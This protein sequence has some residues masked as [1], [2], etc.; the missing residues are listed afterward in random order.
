MNKDISHITFTNKEAGISGTLT[1]ADGF[2]LSGRSSEC[3]LTS[4]QLAGLQKEIYDAICLEYD[5]L[6]D[7]ILTGKH[8]RREIIS[9]ATGKMEKVV[10]EYNKPA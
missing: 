5:I 2:E 1:P 3:D 9:F 4:S 8:Y 6:C 7:A 10:I